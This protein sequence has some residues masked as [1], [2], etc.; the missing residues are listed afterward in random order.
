M[1]CVECAPACSHRAVLARVFDE[2]I[3]VDLVDSADYVHLAAL[4]RPELGVTLTKLHCWT[5]TQYSK[6]VFLDADTLVSA[7]GGETPHGTGSPAHTVPSLSPGCSPP[8]VTRICHQCQCPVRQSQVRHTMSWHVSRPPVYGAHSRFW[9]T[10]SGGKKH[11][12]F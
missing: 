5:L 11:L 10:L 8:Q 7:V 6:C 4:R 9:P 2:V 12:S 1:S 3:E